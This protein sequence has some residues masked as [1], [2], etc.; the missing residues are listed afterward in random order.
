ML[1]WFCLKVCIYLFISQ[2]ITPDMNKRREKLSFW[3]SHCSSP[4]T[5]STSALDRKEPLC[6]RQQRGGARQG[7]KERG[8]TNSILHRWKR[9]LQ[10]K[11][12]GELGASEALL[13]NGIK[14]K[15]QTNG[16]ERETKFPSHVNV[17]ERAVESFWEL[18]KWNKTPSMPWCETIWKLSIYSGQWLNSTNIQSPLLSV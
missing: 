13:Q 12:P 6:R 14:H 11:Q 17:T 10:W 18:I 7:S 2:T 9:S 15:I 4:M 5:P 16:T 3:R 8:V 1:L